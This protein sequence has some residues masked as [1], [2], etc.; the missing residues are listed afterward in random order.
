[1]SSTGDAP[2]RKEKLE[3]LWSS[4]Y[5]RD[6]TR[7]LSVFATEGARHNRTNVLSRQAQHDAWVP[8]QT[9]VEIN[10]RNL[11]AVLA[12]TSAALLLAGLLILVVL[13]AALAASSR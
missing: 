11:V 3:W 7:P 12:R 2:W 1:M 5:V 13:P 6:M 8:R 10:S 4:A 9:A